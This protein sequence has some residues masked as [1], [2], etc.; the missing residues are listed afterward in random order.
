MIGILYAVELL[1]ISIYSALLVLLFV[2]ETQPE[3]SVALLN[4]TGQGNPA[5]ERHV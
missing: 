5:V 2:F 3:C 1:R 4:H